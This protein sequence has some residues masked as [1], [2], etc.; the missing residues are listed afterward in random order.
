M[1]VPRRLRGLS[2]QPLEPDPA[3]TGGGN[4]DDAE[5]LPPQVVSLSEAFFL[6]QFTTAQLW[7]VIQRVRSDG[8]RVHCLTN[9]VAQELTANVLLAA[10]A[11][12]SMTIAPSEIAGFTAS[13]NAVLVNLGTLDETRRESMV[14]AAEQAK[15]SGKPWVLDPVF[16]HRSP[17]RANFA[18]E[19]LAY[20]P[21]VVRANRDEFQALGK[22]PAASPRSVYFES[23]AVDEI[24]QG[25]WHGR[26]ANGSPLMTRMTA[27]GCAMTALVAACC[28]V[29]E[30]AR[31][32][33]TAAAGWFAVAGELAGE[34]AGG[35]GSFKA[36]LLDRLYDLKA[37]HFAAKL[38]YTDTMTGEGT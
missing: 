1:G 5:T 13:A 24:W 36:A 23:G 33:V 32:A 3:C 38:R 7:Q 34:G 6:T 8:P 22:A 35:P 37:D 11:V 9:T 28:V 30:D 18:R 25:D 20:G 4:W 14:L 16:I 2:D 10:G 29:E 17:P 15:T 27:A 31:C 19:L 21:H 12:P 26:V